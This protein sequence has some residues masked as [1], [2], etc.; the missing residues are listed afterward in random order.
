MKAVYKVATRQD[1]VVIEAALRDARVLK[2]VKAI[3]ALAQHITISDDM[4]TEIVGRTINGE[5]GNAG[6]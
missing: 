5:T 3:G 2:L 6:E 1:K 4:L